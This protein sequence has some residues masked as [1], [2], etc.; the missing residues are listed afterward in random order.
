MK[1]CFADSDFVKKKKKKSAVAWK[2]TETA[3]FYSATSKVQLLYLSRSTELH[4]GL[5]CLGQ[6]GSR[7]APGT[8]DESLL[9]AAATRVAAGADYKDGVWSSWWNVHKNTEWLC[10]GASEEE[11]DQKKCLSKQLGL[12]PHWQSLQPQL[13]PVL[14][15]VAVKV[16]CKW[17]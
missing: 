1:P 14:W 5:I 7:W 13:H 15:P 10:S 17:F 2:K 11:E 16:P 12:Y 6:I 3:V 4:Q 8:A 9:A